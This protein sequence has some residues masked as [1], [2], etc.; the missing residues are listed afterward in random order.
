MS[1]LQTLPFV[2]AAALFLLLPGGLVTVALGLRGLPAA[3]LAAPVTVSIASVLAVLLPFVGLPW[4]AAAVL[5]GSILLTALVLAIRRVHEGT[6]LRSSFADLLARTRTAGAEATRNRTGGWVAAAFVAGA[7]LILVELALAFI[8]PENLSQTFDNVFHLN[9]VRYILDTGNASSLTMSKMTSGDAAPYFYPAAWHG[10]AAALIQ[11]TGLPITAA[12]NVLNM[13]V[14]A[15]VWPL[16]CMMLTRTVAGNRPLAVGAA[17]ILAAAFAAFPILPLDFGV[18]Y[19]NFLAIS[20]LPAALASVAVLF[21]VARHL[22]WPPLPGF[23]LPLLIIPGLALAHPNGFMSLVILSVPIVLQAY[24]RSYLGPS[25]QRREHRTQ[26]IL[27]TLG[28][29]AAA[30]A[31][32]VLWTN[33]RPPEDAAFWPPPQTPRGAVFDI[34]TNGAVDRPAAVGVSVLMLLGLFLCWRRGGR[35]WMLAGFVITAVLYVTVSGTLKGDVRSAL[36]GIWYNDSNRIAALLPLTALPFA[37][38]AVDT[39][40][41]WLRRTTDRLAGS[42]RAGTARQPDGNRGRLAFRIISG[43]L[44]AAFIAAQV[45]SMRTAIASAQKNYRETDHSLLITAAEQR[46]IDRLDGIVPAD[47]TIAVNPWT[48]GALAYALAHR[49]TTAKHILT[50]NT[51]DVELLNRKLRDADRDP[52]VCAALA[53]TGVRYVLDFGSNEVHFG[54]HPFPGLQNLNNS[55]AVR[56]VLSDGPARLYEVTACR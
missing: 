21:R 50:A 31:L 5:A 48:G 15:L 1:W 2:A 35:T 14:A 19:P 4:S 40:V 28:L 41:L 25:N 56:L 23:A 33:A 43:L 22:Q 39:L 52:A 34:V 27:A 42:R 8:T 32:P 44:V 46:I 18:L 17:G 53:A 3:A 6:S 24:V 7:A 10:L 16:G 20:V 37:A 55:L 13:A 51:A 45:P 11:L 12:V 49:E 29:A 9:S 47:A 38:V 26:W 36:T 30:V 54:N